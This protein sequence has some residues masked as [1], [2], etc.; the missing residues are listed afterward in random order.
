M[1]P[2]GTVQVEAVQAGAVSEADRAKT[3]PEPSS[4][5]PAVAVGVVALVGVVADQAARLLLAAPSPRR[6]EEAGV[7]DHCAWLC[8]QSACG[9]SP[10][11]TR[12]KT[13]CQP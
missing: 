10:V 4:G 12:A 7:G 13:F 2:A 6:R 1:A 8:L 5:A 11:R 9:G 3:P